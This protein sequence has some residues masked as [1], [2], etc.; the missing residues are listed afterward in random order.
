MES[1]C[2]ELP[3]LPTRSLSSAAA[4]QLGARTRSGASIGQLPQQ[5]GGALE[6]WRSVMSVGGGRRAAASAGMAAAAKRRSTAP[7]VP[8]A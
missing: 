5:T 2:W 3:F 8:A 7:A 1:R 6:G 4:G